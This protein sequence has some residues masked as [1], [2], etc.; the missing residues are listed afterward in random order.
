MRTTRL[1]DQHIAA[2]AMA[3]EHQSPLDIYVDEFDKQ[4]GSALL[5]ADLYSGTVL[6]EASVFKIDTLKDAR[7]FAARFS[8]NGQSLQLLL[9]FVSFEHGLVSAQIL[10]CE[11]TKN[12]RWRNRVSFRHHKGPS[13]NIQLGYSARIDARVAN[14]SRAG[15]AL[16]IW[17]KDYVND[18][19]RSSSIDLEVKFNDHFELR[20]TAKALSAKFVRLPS[21]RTQV[22]CSFSNLGL[23]ERSQLDTFMEAC[24]QFTQ[25]A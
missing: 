12:K 19:K 24:R 10:R 9:R 22:R 21:C 17:S 16:E 5:G 1:S 2:I 23:L 6:F 20:T 11:T 8:Q 7:H 3:C 13:A 15:I 18:I 25:A 4:L 14:V